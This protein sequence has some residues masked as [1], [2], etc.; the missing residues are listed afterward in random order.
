MIIELFKKAY[1]IIFDKYQKIQ[2]EEIK[3]GIMRD[4][5]AIKKINEKKQKE[6]MELYDKLVKE[7]E[8]K[9]E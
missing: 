4:G 5:N 3:Q 2:H 1:C 7:Q 8:Q 6:V 9:K